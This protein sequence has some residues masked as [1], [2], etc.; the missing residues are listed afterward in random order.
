M[1]SVSPVGPDLSDTRTKTLD[2]LLVDILDPNAAID[3]NFINYVVSLNN[4]KVLSGLLAVETASSITL[5]APTSRP[6][7]S[8]VP[9]STPRASSRPGN[10]SC[11]RGWR[12]A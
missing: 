9:T 10:R 11:R 8:S 7:S 1:T 2:A 6:T 4:G 12:R 5:A 3:A